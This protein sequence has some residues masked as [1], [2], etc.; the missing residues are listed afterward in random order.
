M[1]AWQ[2]GKARI[3]VKTS[4]KQIHLFARN[5]KFTVALG[6]LRQVKS[7]PISSNAILGLPKTRN[8]RINKRLVV[9]N[10]RSVAVQHLPEPDPALVRS[11]SI[12][13]IEIQSFP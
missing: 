2:V 11:A 12:S 5:C 7:S 13:L 6:I 9:T 10:G 3:A 1:S 4:S 8:V